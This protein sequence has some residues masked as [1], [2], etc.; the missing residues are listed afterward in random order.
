MNESETVDDDAC[1]DEPQPHAANASTI[2]VPASAA[3]GPL[4]SLSSSSRKATIPTG[5]PTTTLFQ[6]QSHT[7]STPF[8]ESAAQQQL[9]NLQPQSDGLFTFLD[10][11]V[12]LIAQCPSTIGTGSA[13]DCWS[14]GHL[15]SISQPED[16]VLDFP[17]SLP[18][19]PA[20]MVATAVGSATTTAS[21]SM[22]YGST[23]AA[24]YPY[25]RPTSATSSSMSPSLAISSL[26]SPSSE[27]LTLPFMAMLSSPLSV[28]PSSEI[29]TPSS[30]IP[31]S[32]ALVPNGAAT[33]S[34]V[35]APVT[36]CTLKT[37]LADPAATSD[38]SDQSP[39]GKENTP[40]VSTHAKKRK[41]RA[42]KSTKRNGK[43]SK[44]TEDESTM[45]GTCAAQEKD[46]SGENGEN[47]DEAAATRSGRKSNLPS[48]FKDAGAGYAPSKRSVRKK[49]A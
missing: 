10:N 16:D 30:V 9:P 7:L 26:M 49:S 45:V 44:V 4:L 47:V 35:V 13:N 17:L 3:P 29:P 15:S 11:D 24:P 28:F 14:G 1:M 46:A 43:R 33:T 21:E 6:Q 42:D 12:N 27:G 32:G 2:S 18:F 8:V 39:D 41:P 20:Q 5:E 38:Q 19:Q 31:S 34:M 25:M 48:R 40:V 37:S 23:H 36:A 22:V